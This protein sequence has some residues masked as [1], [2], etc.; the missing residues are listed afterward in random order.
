MDFFDKQRVKLKIERGD[1]V[2]PAS[3]KSSDIINALE[4]TLKD[5]GVDI[6]LNS[7]VL[8]VHKEGSK[9]DY[10][11]LDKGEKVI[12]DYFIVCTGGKSYPLTGSRVMA[13]NSQNH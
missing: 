1:R 8:K 10:V 11:L 2:F 6:R 5:N 3:D 9:I 4:W 13:I 7:K 12:G